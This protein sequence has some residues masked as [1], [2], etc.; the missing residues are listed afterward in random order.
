ML[1]DNIG[2]A[3]DF[4]DESRKKDV[5]ESVLHP[6]DL[7][8]NLARLG[9]A[10]KIRVQFSD[11]V[12]FRKGRRMSPLDKVHTF[13]GFFRG[14]ESGILCYTTHRSEYGSVSGYHFYPGQLEK[15]VAYSLI[16]RGAHQHF[17]SLEQFAKR[18]DTKFITKEYIEKLWDGTSSQH[19]G[20]YQRSD[21]RRI[22]K[23]G[24]K[25]VEKFM[26]HFKGVEAKEP[27]EGYSNSEYGFALRAEERA[28]S[29]NGRD[30]SVSH[31]LG[32]EI[33]HYSSEYAGCGNGRYGLL[34]T[35]KTFL[36]LEDD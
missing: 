16:D 8:G 21:F 15:I 36:W 3:L 11:P 28:W 19:G 9:R 4:K 26:Y 35:E 24:L 6:H 29:N 13:C 25:A 23:K 7:E 31:S 34:V 27:P 20:K 18:F 2:I 10:W 17:S 30:I 12:Q 33:V 1:P 14:S 5:L 32:R 22:G